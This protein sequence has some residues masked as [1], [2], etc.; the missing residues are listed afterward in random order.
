M[1]SAKCGLVSTIDSLGVDMRE[2][3]ALKKLTQFRSFFFLS[4]ILWV[5]E[6]EERAPSNAVG[7]TCSSR[8][9]PYS[10]SSTCGVGIPKKSKLER[11][12]KGPTQFVG[13]CSSGKAAYGGWIH[14]QK[15]AKVVSSGDMGGPDID[16][17]MST[18]FPA[19]SASITNTRI[20]AQ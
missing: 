16:L 1:K 15:H 20:T 18:S 7:D 6:K 17:L 14:Q 12:K 5:A 3:E 8:T 9:L 10:P 4:C 13:D 19:K 2:C 11:P